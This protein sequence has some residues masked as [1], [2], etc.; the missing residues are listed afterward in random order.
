MDWT[1]RV[2]LDLSGMDDLAMNMQVAWLKRSQQKPPIAMALSTILFDRETIGVAAG[3]F[4]TG[5]AEMDSS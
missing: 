2:T 3:R 1:K 4:I 5:S